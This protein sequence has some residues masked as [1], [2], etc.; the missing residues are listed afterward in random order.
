MLFLLYLQI[1]SWFNNY[2]IAVYYTGVI[3]LVVSVYVHSDISI[4]N[5]LLIKWNVRWLTVKEVKN[6]LNML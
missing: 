3:S 6:E 1:A 2:S 4:I 5:K